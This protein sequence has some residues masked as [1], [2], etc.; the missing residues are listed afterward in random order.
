MVDSD[1]SSNATERNPFDAWRRFVASL[2]AAGATLESATECLEVTERADAVRALQRAALNQLARLELDVATPE[3]VPFNGWRQKFFM[4]NP[5]C[6]YF[7]AEISDSGRYR[8]SGSIRGAAFASVTVYS[9]S[10]FDVRAVARATSDDLDIHDDGTFSLIL[11]PNG[12]DLDLP[13]GSNVVWVRFFHEA[14]TAPSDHGTASIERLDAA[15]TPPSIDPGAYAG[16]L[17]RAGGTV[18]LA[19]GVI[20]STEEQEIAAGDLNGVR[21]WEQMSGGAVYTEP[22]ISYFRGAWDL[23]DD[24]ALEV[25]VAIPPCRHWSFLLYSRHLNSLDARNRTVSLTERTVVRDDDGIVRVR[26]SASDPGRANWLDTEGRR[27]GVFVIRALQ[28]TRAPA[29][30]T[31]RRVRLEELRHD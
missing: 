5:D 13:V 6:G 4:D 26:I 31:A 15:A 1:A 20:G 22:G 3:L 7:V 17:L 16:R 12:A 24:E 11:A 8:I 23:A 19:A 10:G 18:E 14:D 9:G 29:L 25:E 21:A 28:P 27:F 2:D 30:P